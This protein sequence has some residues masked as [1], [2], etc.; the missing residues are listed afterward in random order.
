MTVRV[1]AQEVSALYC[2][3]CDTDFQI[4]YEHYSWERRKRKIEPQAHSAGY[5]TQVR[6]AAVSY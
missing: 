3:Y 5:S 6:I 4:G 1:L 2:N